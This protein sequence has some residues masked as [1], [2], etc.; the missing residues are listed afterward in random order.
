MHVLQ[1]EPTLVE[2]VT[3]WKLVP[4]Y[5]RA[6]T[7]RGSPPVECARFG[8]VGA[9]RSPA[10]TTEG[11]DGTAC[12]TEAFE[13]MGVGRRRELASK[14]LAGSVDR[15]ERRSAAPR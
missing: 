12:P 2:T 10:S 4:D 15:H 1:L 5:T 3:A 13:A 9:G 6:V 8:L 11:A 14:R 7:T